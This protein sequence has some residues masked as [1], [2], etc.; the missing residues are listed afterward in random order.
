MPKSKTICCAAGTN[1]AFIYDPKSGEDVTD[2]I[3]T[4]E[5]N[6]NS[7]YYLQLLKYVNEPH[8]LLLAT[9]SRKQLIIYKYNPSGCITSLK[10]KHTLDSLC[11]TAKV[12][13]LIFTGD[14]TGSVL[15]WEQR[16][17]NEL[18]YGNESLLKSETVIKESAKVL[19]E[20]KNPPPNLINPTNENNINVNNNAINNRSSKAKSAVLFNRNSKIKSAPPPTMLSQYEKSK[21]SI[22]LKNNANKS[23]SNASKTEKNGDASN[24]IDDLN[25]IKKTNVV[26]RMVFIESLDILF[27]ACED[28]S[29][30]VWGFDEDAVK[31]LK[32]MKFTEEKRKMSDTNFQ[33]YKAY[34][35]TLQMNSFTDDLDNTNE[36]EDETLQTMTTRSEEDNKVDSVTNRVAGLILK[37]VL[38]EHRNCVTCLV[39]IE[40]LDLYPL[41]YLL[42][43][44]W[45]RRICIW[46]LDPEHPTEQERKE[47]KEPKEQKPR[48]LLVDVFKNKLANSLEE[49]E[50]ASDGHILDICYCPKHNLFAYSSSDSMVYIRKF[51]MHG[52]EMTLVYTLQGHLSDVNCVR[53]HPVKELWVTGGEDGTIRVWVKKG[54]NYI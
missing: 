3:D 52:S 44:G 35:K 34:L 30:Y 13:I 23:I 2:F 50:Y 48:I 27:A 46:S 11:H 26:L 19:G 6:N 31:V 32:E 25:K 20:V 21:T 28:G 49:S 51:A 12:P 4:F 17:S 29:I 37:K 38:N 5:T 8:N 16:Q 33:Y 1:A 41:R 40:R 47:Q 36:N 24:G 53:W 7:N 10:Y 18:I 42:S 15:K 43:S 45:D 39:S 22:S 54:K 14:S 9:T